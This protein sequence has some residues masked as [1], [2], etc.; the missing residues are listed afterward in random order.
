MGRDKS[1]WVDKPEFAWTP[2]KPLHAA[3][4]ARHETRLETGRDPASTD[5]VPA[6]S[7]VAAGWS[8]PLPWPARPDWNRI[9][10]ALRLAIGLVQG[11][12]L[13]GL[14]HARDHNLWPHAV[15][16]DSLIMVAAMAPLLLIQGLGEIPARALLIWTACTSVCLAGLGAYHHWRMEG[17]VAGHSGLWLAAQ[18]GILLF[19]GQSLLLSEA[20]SG[21]GPLQYARVFESSWA[22]AIQLLFSGLFALLI[23]LGLM[24]GLGWLEARSTVSSIPDFVSVPAATL[25]VAL[26]AHVTG[27]RQMRKAVRGLAWLFAALLP[28]LL[29]LI[30]LTIMVWGLAHWQPPF[31]LCAIEGLFLILSIN[32]SYRGGT[33]WR[34]QW[35]RWL[36]FAGAFLLPVPAAMA[37]LSLLP[38]IGEFGFTAPRAVVVALVM[39]L[40]AYGVT[41]IAA[42]LISLSG[43]RW[44]Q[45]LESANFLMAFVTLSL[46]AALS[47]PLADPVRLAVANQAWRIRHGQIAPSRFDYGY[48]RKSGLRFGHVLLE[49]LARGPIKP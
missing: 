28:V 23:G 49:E 13:I 40:W 42:A 24:V 2:D 4:S 17:A 19:V 29:V 22:L 46:I 32:A 3:P 36:E 45:R 39:L 8:P 11:L 7:G 16:T 15:W 9:Y 31:L 33:Y 25:A 37:S 38:R 30:S 14:M 35:R 44:M 26:A 1:R 21:P 47:S 5:P 18:A 41:Y 43:G 48:L 20:R 12:C 10:F 34:P 27:L 6:G